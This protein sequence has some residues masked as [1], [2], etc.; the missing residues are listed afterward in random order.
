V[1]AA[2]GVPVGAVIVG[3]SPA[4]AVT[5]GR[6]DDDAVEL[7]ESDTVESDIELTPNKIA[8]SMIKTRTAASTARNE[9]FIYASLPFSFSL[10]CI[11]LAVV[12]RLIGMQGF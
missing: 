6:A 10:H 4:F 2:G 1:S 7:V 11:R 5:R 9:F 8:P 3:A 12:K